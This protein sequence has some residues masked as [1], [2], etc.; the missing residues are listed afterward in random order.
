M[1]VQLPTIFFHLPLNNKLQ[2]IDVDNVSDDNVKVARLEFEQPWNRSNEI[3]TAMAVGV[4]FLLM[5]VALR[6]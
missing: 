4:S 6:Q 3:R 2:K 5:L 1:G